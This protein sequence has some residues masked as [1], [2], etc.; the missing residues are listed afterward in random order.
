MCVSC[1]AELGKQ[2]LTALSQSQAIVAGGT[3]YVSGQIPGKPDGKLVEGNIGD[4]TAQCCENIKAILAEAGSSI[5][6]VVVRIRY[7]LLPLNI[8]DMPCRVSP[9]QGDPF[10]I[11]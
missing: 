5:E 8:A 10:R 11:S 4:K 3:I 1:R 9:L 2:L 6:R 7:R